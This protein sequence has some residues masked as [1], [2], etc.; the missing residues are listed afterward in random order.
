MFFAI[1]TII[2][3]LFE[4]IGI[5]TSVREDYRENGQGHAR[6]FL[7]E[8]FACHAVAAIAYFL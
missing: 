4:M 1:L 6:K 5:I 7:V 8:G 2:D 3:A